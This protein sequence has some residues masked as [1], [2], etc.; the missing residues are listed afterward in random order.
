MIGCG[1]AHAT[2]RSAGL[3]LSARRP[4]VEHLADLGT[5]GGEFAVR[6]L[7]IGNDQVQALGRAGR[8][9]RDL[10]AELDRAL[11]ARRRELDDPDAVIEGEV[12]VEPPPEAPV[13]LFRA[14]NIR[15]GDDDHLKLRVHH[16]WLLSPVLPCDVS[17]LMSVLS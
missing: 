7:N 13:E 6:S 9:R 14:V 4:G 17:A 12:S 15:D 16:A 1:A 5:A 10:R 3:E 2:A 8:G 11:R